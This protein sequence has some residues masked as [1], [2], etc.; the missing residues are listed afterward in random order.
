MSIK[1]KRKLALFLVGFASTTF[2]NPFEYEEQQ[3][4]PK[5]RKHSAS[6][7]Y[8]E[9]HATYPRPRLPMFGEEDKLEYLLFHSGFR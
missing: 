6:L 8:N 5:K 4:S 3:A 7:T 9:F 2:M 1:Q